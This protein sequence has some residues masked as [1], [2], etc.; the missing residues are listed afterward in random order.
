MNE[1]TK[2][3]IEDTSSEEKQSIIASIK[4][5]LIMKLEDP[6]DTYSLFGEG[7]KP[8]IHKH[9][10]GVENPVIE[11]CNA[12]FEKDRQMKEEIGSAFTDSIASC[13]VK[14]YMKPEDFDPKETYKLFEESVVDSMKSKNK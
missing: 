9:T 5:K 3:N 11:S 8:A 2:I 1:N 4:T 12:N 6:T 7:G 13:N 10:T 14:V